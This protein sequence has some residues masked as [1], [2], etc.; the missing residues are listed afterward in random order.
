MEGSPIGTTAIGIF[1]YD[2]PEKPDGFKLFDGITPLADTVG[3]K[4]FAKFVAGI[5][6]PLSQLRNPRGGFITMSTSE[7]SQRFVEA[8]RAE[9]DVSRFSPF[10][11]G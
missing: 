3:R 5:P 9:V 1:F 4:P 7:I 6:A 2:G 10:S 8:V 11:F